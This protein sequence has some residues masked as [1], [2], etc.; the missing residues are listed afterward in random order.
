M[1]VVVVVVVAAFTCSCMA[2]AMDEYMALGWECRVY[3]KHALTFC[4]VCWLSR[5]SCLQAIVLA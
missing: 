5:C 2:V 3:E 1:A 4:F